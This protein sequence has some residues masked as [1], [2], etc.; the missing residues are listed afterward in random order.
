MLVLLP[1]R[2]QSGALMSA[3]L[4]A[5]VPP[6]NPSCVGQSASRLR[7]VSVQVCAIHPTRTHGVDSYQHLQLAG[8]TRFCRSCVHCALVF[9]GNDIC[10]LPKVTGPCE[11]LMPS[12]YYDSEEGE[13]IFFHYG[14]CEGNENRFDTQEACE[15]ACKTGNLC[16]CMASA[17][18][19]RWS[20][21]TSMCHLLL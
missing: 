15:E 11:A 18:C 4:V 6:I 20:K 21:M 14:G 17:Q 2:D 7:N 16:Q 3:W 13:C 9:S 10:L 12:W 19:I 5:S 8:R 1:A